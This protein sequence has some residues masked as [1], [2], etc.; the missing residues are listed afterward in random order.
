VLCNDKKVID[1]ETSDSINIVGIKKFELLKN[2]TIRSI[3]L[4]HIIIEYPLND[5]EFHFLCEL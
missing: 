5:S 3:K 1:P 4:I 2:M